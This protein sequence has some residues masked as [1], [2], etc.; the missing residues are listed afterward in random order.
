M[1]GGKICVSVCA[2]TVDE[3]IANIRCA[4]KFADLVEVRFDCLAEREFDLSGDEWIAAW[5]RIVGSSDIVMI[6]TLRPRG[7]GGHR[8]LG[9]Q[10]RA[11]FWNSGCETE[12]CDIEDPD[13]ISDGRW[14]RGKKIISHHDFSETPPDLDAI[15]ARLDAADVDIIKIATYANDISDTIA[16]WKLLE[17]AKSAGKQII[18]I[19]MGEAGKW[20]RVL[21]PAHGAFLTYA[22]LD[23]RSETADGQVTASDLVDVYRV[24][25]LTPD[26]AVYGV[27]G[28]S[29][30]GSLSPYIHNAAFRACGI[31]AVFLPLQVKHLDEFICR[32]VRRETREVQL[33][34]Q[35]FA[36]TMPHKLAVMKHLDALDPAADAIGAVNTVK[37]EGSRLIGYNTDADGFLAPI[38]ERFG[39]LNGAR[40]A[41]FGAGGAARACVYALKKAGVAVTVVARD[42]VQAKELARQFEIVGTTI[43]DFKSEIS[44]SPGVDLIVNATPIGMDDHHLQASLLSAGEL[45]N[46]K[47]V[48]DL[49]TTAGETPLLK[50]AKKAGIPTV[51]GVEMLIAQAGRQFEIWT[52][53]K[54]PIEL[55]ER[56]ARDRLNR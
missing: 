3:M 27:I 42:K 11:A 46:S 17:K 18:P 7:Q 47:L 16:S 38:I 10:D 30:S 49:V 35:G 12:I 41:V 29:V 34:F 9:H 15:Y 53:R 56:T 26:T 50:E 28:D 51:E 48:Y 40:A 4:A 37:I 33:N 21:G 31:D 13:L 6:S 44:N 20:T 22:S 39:D 1:N 23:Q 25:E 19:A 2:E 8:A 43:S 36:V 5:R 52:G 24:K 55:M 32:M 54:A 45:T 14:M